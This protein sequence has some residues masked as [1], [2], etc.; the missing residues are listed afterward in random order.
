MI[1]QKK[2]ICLTWKDGQSVLDF[3]KWK[4]FQSLA[5]FTPHY[6]IS[7]VLTFPQTHHSF[8]GLYKFNNFDFPVYSFNNIGLLVVIDIKKIGKLV[9]YSPFENKEQ[10]VYI[11][12]A[13]LE[14]D[15][16][17]KLFKTEEGKSKVKIRIAEKFRLENI[18]V[19]AFEGLKSVD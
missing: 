8:I 12:V 16:L 3:K 19:N 9:Q 10:E 5:S 15:D 4:E 13:E 2:D 6:R 7:E 1:I 17:K 18:D 11:D 14:E